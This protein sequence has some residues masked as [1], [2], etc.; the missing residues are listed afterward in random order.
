MR[1]SFS[2]AA[3]WIIALL[4]M[5]ILQSCSAMKGSGGNITKDDAERIKNTNIAYVFYHND[6]SVEEDGSY[7]YQ[8]EGRDYI[9][10]YL[11]A[12]GYDVEFVGKY[13]KGTLF[14]EIIQSDGTQ[15]YTY[16]SDQ[17]V[18][19][20]KDKNGNVVGTYNQP[21]TRYKYKSWTR[22]DLYVSDPKSSYEARS[23]CHKS[24]VRNGSSYNSRCQSGIATVLSVIPSRKKKK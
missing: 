12:K 3:N 24:I 13:R 17:V 20:Y 18:G 4:G 5:A 23:I 8:P 11:K 7:Q 16:R 15:E 22:F 6:G 9:K 21:T 2:L 14:I 1:N 19:T 10:K